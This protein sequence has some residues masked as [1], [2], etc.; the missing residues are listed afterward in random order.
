MRSSSARQ[1]YSE[2]STSPRKRDYSKNR[3]RKANIPKPAGRPPQKPGTRKKH[4]TYSRVT[5]NSKAMPQILKRGNIFFIVE[6]EQG[7]YRMPRNL[8]ISLFVIFACALAIVLTHAQIT[9]M[10]RQIAQ[11]R[12]RLHLLDEYN[13]NLESQIGGNYT[14]EE[15]EYIAIMRLGMTP[16]DPSQIIE[17]NVPRQSHVEFNRSEHTLSGRENY[18]WLDIRNFISGALD[19]I[20]GGN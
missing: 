3:A 7:Q 15:I 1:T 20:F 16:P 14:L 17:I 19:R 6:N 11:E 9:G 8:I 5:K 13:R 4:P 12:I 10:E 2:G 18:F